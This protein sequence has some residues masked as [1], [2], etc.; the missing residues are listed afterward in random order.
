MKEALGR[1]LTPEAAR[2]CQNC[3]GTVG[4]ARHLLTA[5]G[6]G[7]RRVSLLGREEAGVLRQPASV[8]KVGHVFGKGL[9]FSQHLG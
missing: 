3:L 1:G 2:L 7:R 4:R 9:K 5:A 6:M 8:L